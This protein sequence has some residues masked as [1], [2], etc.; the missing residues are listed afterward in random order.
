MAL[1]TWKERGFLCLGAVGVVHRLD[2]HSGGGLHLLLSHLWLPPTAVNLMY[3]RLGTPEF[4]VTYLDAPTAN[5][6]ATIFQSG[7]VANLKSA[8]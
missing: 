2:Q 5:K 8:D 4:R 7:R 3:H 1:G 6:I